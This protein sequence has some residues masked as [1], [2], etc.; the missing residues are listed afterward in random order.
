MKKQLFDDQLRKSFE[1]FQ[2]PMDLEQDW[3]AIKNKLPKQKKSNRK[4]LL[5]LLL[6]PGVVGSFLIWRIYQ[7]KNNQATISNIDTNEQKFYHNEEKSEN[8]I[9]PPKDPI[10]MDVEHLQT[11]NT[12]APYHEERR[13]SSI[14]LNGDYS[15]NSKQLMSRNKAVVQED[16]ERDNSL[17]DKNTLFNNFIPNGANS[18]S[19]QNNIDKNEIKLDNAAANVTLLTK[20]DVESDPMHQFPNSVESSMPILTIKPRLLGFN[21]NEATIND[22]TKLEIRKNRLMQNRIVFELAYGFLNVKRS[23]PS[24]EKALLME[25]YNNGV[26]PLD[27]IHTG[28]LF[29]LGSKAYN[30]FETGLI[31]S[32]SSYL[33]KQ[34]FIDTSRISFTDTTEIIEYEDGSKEI[35]VGNHF[36]N[37]IW[38]INRNNIILR[39]RLSIPVYYTQAIM[40]SRSWN[41]DIK[42]GLLINVLDQYQGST[43]RE[44]ERDINLVSAYHYYKKMSCSISTQLGANIFYSPAPHHKIGI[45]L[46]Y[47]T[48]LSP[49]FTPSA[50]WQEK[51]SWIIGQLTYKY[52]I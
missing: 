13:V 33:F 41:L 50:S 52:K 35:K 46:F 21:M 47:G 51:E 43:F 45:G 5:L 20:I 2:V 39:K 29:Q 16:S 12:Q 10:N 14:E 34:K 4:I 11:L 28:L 36:G 7:P 38:N 18:L 3:N 15:A 23:Q 26:K 30:G 48:D 37:R 27:K 42:W 49:R 19:N 31:Y 6:L 32:Q 44:Y 17:H 9:T 40:A 22:L 1:D 25:K 8:G 24:D